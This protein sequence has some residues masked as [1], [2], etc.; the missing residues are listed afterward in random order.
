MNIGLVTIHYANSYGGVLQ[1][2]ATQK[3]LLNYGN[4]EIIN[5]QKQHLADGLKTIRLGKR[6]MDL[7]RTGKDVLRFIP[8]KKLVI[9][10]KEFI[11]KHMK[12]SDV[13]KN[14]HEADILSG[15][16]DILVV[17]SDQVWN[18]EIVGELDEIYFLAFGEKKCKISLSSSYGSYKFKEHERDI[19]KS[20][21]KAFSSIS[22]RE[23][24]S[25]NELQELLGITNI[26]TTLDPTLM[27][28]ANDWCQIIEPSIPKTKYILVY[29]LGNDVL[30]GNSVKIIQDILGFKV[31]TINQDPY[32]NFKSDEHVKNAGPLEFIE[33]FKNASFVVTNSFHGT[34][35][36]VNFNK[37]FITLPP[38][39]GANRIIN[40]LRN[41]KLERRYLE[42]TDKISETISSRIKYN[43]A[44]IALEELR[45]ESADYIKEA[46]KKCSI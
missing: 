45:T 41:L 38:H 10:F 20:K 3:I 30:L 5:Y 16:Y 18:P 24:S 37:E 29:L 7:L 25:S 4:V 32:I 34:A 43:E 9:R 36:S 33:F 8:R 17:G 23:E 28:T 27:L 1:A 44:N 14:R 6:P 46:I 42:S 12:C 39:S 15:K 22:V 26:K 2:Y 11:A 19:V 31:I 35:F 13:I 40:L 21:L